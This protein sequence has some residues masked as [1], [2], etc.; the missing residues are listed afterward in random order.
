MTYPVPGATR[1]QVGKA[2]EKIAPTGRIGKPL[3][4]L[5]GTPDVLLP[6][7]RDSDVYARM[8]REAGRGRPHRYCRI[9]GGTH[10]DAPADRFPDRLRPLVPCHR[11]AFAA[12]DVRLA[13]GRRS[14]AS[15]T[16]A[17]PPSGTGSAALANSCSLDTAG[18]AGPPS[19]F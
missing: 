10:A 12:L 9:D 11:T 1:G 7:G 17:R 4:T 2:V 6:I 5:H 13:G 3:I 19:T 8:V 18:A 16:V 15:G 14:P